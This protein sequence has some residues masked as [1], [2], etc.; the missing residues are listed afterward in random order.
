[1]SLSF[2]LKELAE[3]L[4]GSFRGDPQLSL[5]GIA[6]LATA[7]E[8]DLTFLTHARYAS[9]A[10]TTG[11]SAILCDKEIDGLAQAFILV[12]NPYLSLAKVIGIFHPAKVY[13]PGIREGAWVDR[14]AQIDPTA[15]IFAGATVGAGAKVGPR[16]VILPGVFLGDEASVGE[17]CLLYPNVVVREKCQIGNRVILQPGV[18]V[19]ADGFGFARDKDRYVKIPQVGNVV[20][21]DDVE[22]GAN[23]CVD[24]AALGTTRIGKGTKLD[25]LIQIGHNVVIGEHGVFAAQIGIAGSTTVGDFARFGG[26]AAIAGH[27][28]IGD[29]VTLAARTGVMEDI[30]KKG[31]Y[32][33]APSSPM[34]QEMKNVAAYR[35]LPDLIKRVHRLERALE[36]LQG[37][38]KH[39]A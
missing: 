5:R 37:T 15:A 25:N 1:M 8:G 32:W 20:I 38:S 30:P 35:Q 14:T 33:G 6:S 22:L 2:T 11:A 21:E 17:D 28:E 29:Q 31:L 4:G 34:T 36:K 24:R 18:V 7:Q 13:E 39:E 10:R 23:T 3:Q 9:A 19:G 27:L 12:P 26:Q 16:S